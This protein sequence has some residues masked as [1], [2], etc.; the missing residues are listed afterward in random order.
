MFETFNVPALYIANPAALSFYSAGRTTGIVCDSGDGVTQILPIYD[1]FKI[2]HGMRKIPIGGRNIT[3]FMARLFL[4]ERA[5][6]C[7][8]SAKKDIMREIKEKLCF[9]SQDYE[10]DL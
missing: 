9:V 6:E 5:Y 4:F 8:S 10:R 7:D 2:N 3:N 1:G